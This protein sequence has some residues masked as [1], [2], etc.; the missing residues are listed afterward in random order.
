MDM[1][2]LAPAPRGAGEAPA[3]VRLFT[4]YRVRGITARNRVVISPMQQYAAVEGHANDWHLVHL[5]RFALGGAG[6]VFVGSTAVERRGRNTHGDLG[7]WHDAQVAP[8][9][10]VARNLKANGAVPAI[11]LGHT[12]RKGGLQKWWEGHGPLNQT[13]DLAR[14]EGPWPLVGP[15][16]LPVGEGWPTPATLGID[17]IQ[18][19][20]AEWGQAARRAHEAGFEWLEVH[21]AHG[22]LIHQFLSP[23]A[24]QRTDAYGGDFTR[25]QRLALEVAES[26]RRHWPDHL[27]LS[28]RI[29]LADLDDDSLQRDELLTFVRALQARGVDLIDASS[30]GGISSYPT[31]VPRVARGLGFR[32]DDGAWLR[33]ATGVPVLAVGNITAPDQAEALLQDGQADL[34]AIGREALHNPNWAVHA[35]IE[36][37]ANKDF[38]LWPRN[39]RM[40][41]ARRAGATPSKDWST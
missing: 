9:A 4:P 13:A 27:P 34:V 26:V 40:W 6:V 15:S 30:A 14:G 32:A 37:G 12:G 38:A 39:Y 22:Y 19:L 16:A 8:L 1:Q 21:G 35:Q 28:W 24:N 23:I 25:R 18:A 10:R 36:L 41:L 20:V 17:E 11:Q 2:T 5:A 3:A 31:N 29:S 7:L 33:Q